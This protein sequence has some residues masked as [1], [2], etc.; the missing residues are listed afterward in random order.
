MPSC[1]VWLTDLHR[2]TEAVDSSPINQGTDEQNDVNPKEP[3]YEAETEK[4][5]SHSQTNLGVLDS[6]LAERQATSTPDFVRTTIE[7]A[8]TAAELDR[9]DTEVERSEGTVAQNED[10]QQAESA[11]VDTADTTELTQNSE[12]HETNEVSFQTGLLYESHY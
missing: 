7:V 6:A 8:D 2:T 9:S 11:A 5:Q 10:G 12:A 3:P 1:L 4:V